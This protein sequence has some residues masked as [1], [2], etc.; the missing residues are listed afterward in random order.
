MEKLHELKEKLWAELE[1]L[2]EKRDMGAGDLEVV[3][4]ITDT[5][6]NIDKICML[7]EEGGYS[8]AVDGMDYGRGSSYANR[9]KHYV[10][11]H[12][13]R[14]GGRD[15]T[16]GY[17]SRRDNRGRYSRDDGRSE[18]MEHLEMALD[19]ASDQD[20]ETIKRFM[21]QLENA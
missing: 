15:G 8:E 10:R 1:E 18:M 17:S 3:H 2:A 12:Y 21:R 7:E 16:G 4:K 6:K 13:S 14:D 19:S 5:I 11:G 9:G 20:R